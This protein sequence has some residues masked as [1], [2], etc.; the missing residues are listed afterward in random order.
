MC[1]F[2]SKKSAP[3]EAPRRI[4]KKKKNWCLFIAGTSELSTKFGVFF[5]SFGPGIKDCKKGILYVVPEEY[6]LEKV[7]K[8]PTAYNAKNA[9]LE[10]YGIKHEY[11]SKFLDFNDL[12][13]YY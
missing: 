11:K 5:T 8:R 10:Y 6:M 1:Y 4:V 13:F 12:R 7:G 9:I 3:I 2:L